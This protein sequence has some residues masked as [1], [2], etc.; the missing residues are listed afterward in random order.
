M[1]GSMAVEQFVSAFKS[2]VVDDNMRAYAEVVATRT[3]DDVA[4]AHWKRA[5]GLF[6]SASPEQ[7]DIIFAVMR[8]VAVDTVSSVFGVLDGVSAIEGLP[9]EITVTY[10]GET[11]SG[12]LQDY[13]LSLEEEASP[14]G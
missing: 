13:F 8:Q 5:L 2:G 6:S 9:G 10:G 14:K 12:E 1:S 3:A 4:D 11:V 7:R